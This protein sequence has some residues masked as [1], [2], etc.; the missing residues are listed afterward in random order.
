[1]SDRAVARI[2]AVTALIDEIDL[3]D[4]FRAVRVSA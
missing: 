2:A 4:G 3:N 1:L